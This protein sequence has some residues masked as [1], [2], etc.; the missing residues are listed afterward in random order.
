MT[1]GAVLYDRAW[2]LLSLGRARCPKLP[3]RCFWVYH[4][5]LLHE[6]CAVP[7]GSAIHRSQ[8]A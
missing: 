8:E 6:L 1:R 4:R 2:V 5:P 3:S 7:M